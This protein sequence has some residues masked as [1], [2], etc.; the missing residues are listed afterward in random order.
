MK[1]IYTIHAKNASEFDSLCNEAMVSGH[2][3]IFAFNVIEKSNGTNFYQ[4][5]Q[6]DDSEFYLRKL[7]PINKLEIKHLNLSPNTKRILISANIKTLED[8]VNTN[9]LPLMIGVKSM[10]ALE[11]LISSLNLNKK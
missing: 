10:E 1:V 3:P 8:I 5:W 7:L 9:K 4:Q 2:S 6:R 11:D